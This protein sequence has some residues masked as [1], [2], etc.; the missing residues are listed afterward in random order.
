[1]VPGYPV[2]YGKN[3]SEGYPKIFVTAVQLYTCTSTFRGA[4]PIH[5][6]DFCEDFLVSQLMP[7]SYWPPG[8]Q[9]FSWFTC[10]KQA[11]STGS[12]RLDTRTLQLYSVRKI[13]EIRIKYSEFFQNLFLQYEALVDTG[14]VSAFYWVGERANC[15]GLVPEGRG[16]PLPYN[17][18]FACLSK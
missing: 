5:H 3:Y 14:W 17:G 18:C 12:P 8:F 2:S 10:T 1:M 7:K 9:K 16:P 11:S 6:E 13:S 15:A 4:R